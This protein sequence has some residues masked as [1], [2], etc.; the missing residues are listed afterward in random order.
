MALAILTSSSGLAEVGVRNPN[1][2]KPEWMLLGDSCTDVDFALGLIKRWTPPV[3]LSAISES[4]KLKAMNIEVVME[5]NETTKNP[6]ECQ[7]PFTQTLPLWIQKALANE[8][9]LDG[10]NCWGTALRAANLIPGFRFASANEISFWMKS[11]LCQQLINQDP[12]PGDLYLLREKVNNTFREIHAMTYIAANLV[13]DKGGSQGQ[14]GYKIADMFRRIRFQSNFVNPDQC[15]GVEG[16]PPQ[17]TSVLHHFRCH[18]FESFRH[19]KV[20]FDQIS[21]NQLSEKVQFFLNEVLDLEIQLSEILE[22]KKPINS[23]ILQKHQRLLKIGIGEISS[24]IT[25]DTPLVTHSKSESFLWT[26]LLF[27]LRSMD[28]HFKQVKQGLRD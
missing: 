1:G 24:D 28:E 5:K 7:K 15:T 6:D 8:T 17:C 11:P 26:N 2:G 20:K 16:F 25:N 12:L 23:A 22:N 4:A 18:S 3:D 21:F 27:R 19:S 14:Y 9:N 13:F 10:P